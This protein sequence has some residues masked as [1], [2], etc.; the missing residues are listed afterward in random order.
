MHPAT[1][2]YMW[3]EVLTS[4]AAEALAEARAVLRQKE[5][6]CQVSEVL[7]FYSEKNAM[8]SSLKLIAY[9]AGADPRLKPY[10]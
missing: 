8:G 5:S 1:Y 2:G 10:A 9:S 4:D 7:I 3:A 6:R